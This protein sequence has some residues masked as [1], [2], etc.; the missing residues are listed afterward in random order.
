MFRPV[1]ENRAWALRLCSYLV[2]EHGARVLFLL[3]TN[4]N[5]PFFQVPMPE[6]GHGASAR[7]VL[8][9]GQHVDILGTQCV[10]T[11]PFCAGAQALVLGH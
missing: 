10:N 11:A 9:H 5:T 1:P 3:D 7:V 2:P 4:V 6:F 8:G